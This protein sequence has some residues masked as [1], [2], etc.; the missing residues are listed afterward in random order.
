[1]SM[2]IMD[3]KEK[4]NSHVIRSKQVHKTTSLSTF[5]R[6]F[7]LVKG[8]PLYFYE[9]PFGPFWKSSD[10]KEGYK[11]VKNNNKSYKTNK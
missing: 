8:V 10:A 1:M 6:S 9:A 5:F 11:N 7:L 4:K 3:E 2:W